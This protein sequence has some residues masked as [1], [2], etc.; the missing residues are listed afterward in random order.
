ML[1]LSVG[2]CRLLHNAA[3]AADEIRPGKVQGSE[4]LVKPLSS[5][6]VGKKNGTPLQ[7]DVAVNSS[8]NLARLQPTAYCNLGFLVLPSY[9]PEPDMHRPVVILLCHR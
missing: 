2:W 6:C 9:L 5:V 3:T 1:S 4:N 7:G 8:S